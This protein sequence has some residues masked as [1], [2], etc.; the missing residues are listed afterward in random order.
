MS[1]VL[2]ATGLV[3]AYKGRRV[4]DGMSMNV[5]AGEIVGTPARRSPRVVV[6]VARVVG[7]L[8]L[9]HVGLNGRRQLALVAAQLAQEMPASARPGAITPE[10][11]DGPG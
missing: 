8:D 9:R 3:K 1:N 2:S 6:R 7:R 10:L 11:G 4:V 5:N